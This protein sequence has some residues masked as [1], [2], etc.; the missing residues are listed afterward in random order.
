MELGL[1]NDIK[2]NSLCHGQIDF[3]NNCLAPLGGS[4][5]GRNLKTVHFSMAGSTEGFWSFSAF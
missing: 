1:K 5:V 2:N 3:V 4:G